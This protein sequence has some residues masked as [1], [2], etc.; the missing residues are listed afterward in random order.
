M[1]VVPMRLARPVYESL[2]YVYMAL[3]ALAIFIFYLDP[4]GTRAVAAFAIGVILAT[5]GL[6]L[7]LRR[8]DYR[9]LSRE[10]SGETIE[11]PSTLRG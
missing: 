9:A 10:Y 3:G 2:P 7:L 1:E 8:Q 11:L 4:A 6:T 5:A